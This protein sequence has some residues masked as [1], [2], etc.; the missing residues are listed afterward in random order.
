MASEARYIPPHARQL[1]PNPDP[2]DS[3]DDEGLDLVP[4]KFK[5]MICHDVAQV[6]T[7]LLCP[8]KGPDSCRTLTCL[9][10]LRDYLKLSKP[11]NYRGTAKC[12]ICH[13][14]IASGA[15][16]CNK[17]YRVVDDIFDYMDDAVA[18]YKP[19]SKCRTCGKQCTG[20]QN[21]W[22]HFCNECP[23]STIQ[24]RHPGCTKW[25]L[26]KFIEGEH[27][28]DHIMIRCNLCQRSFG[29]RQ[30]LNHL[31]EEREIFLKKQRDAEYSLDWISTKLAE[32]APA[33]QPPPPPP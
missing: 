7:R 16:V 32:L 10:C 6:P 21:L 19:A 30:I 17:I 25:G 18:D 1:P 9:R 26:R 31:R 23:D 15:G 8:S 33:D 12:L 29:K 28:E 20:Q 2:E 4:D 11:P 27:A 24:C 13:T 14:E 3:D 22:R 5:C